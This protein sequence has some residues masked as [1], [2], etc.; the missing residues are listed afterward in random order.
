MGKSV[1]LG[2]GAG[3]LDIHRGEEEESSKAWACLLFIL[4]S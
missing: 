1:G 4:Q 2:F 3:F